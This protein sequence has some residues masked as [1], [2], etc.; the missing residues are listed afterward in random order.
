MKK[1]ISLLLALVM[2]MGLS[3]TAFAAENEATQTGVPTS[4]N[5]AITADYDAPDAQYVHTYKATV[6]WEQTGTIKY[7]AATTVYTWNTDKLEY[8]STSNTENNNWTIDNAKVKITVTNYSDQAIT[9]NLN[10]PTPNSSAG[11]DGI[12]GFY[13]GDKRELK[14]ASAY[15]K[16]GTSEATKDY[17]TFNISTVEG[18]I[19]QQGATIATVT[20]KLSIDNNG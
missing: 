16:D 2:V 19:T 20:V 7:T 9:A 3:V 18:A 12:G 10:A 14:L 11:V 15:V 4:S 13:Y 17:T 8:D 1:I 6:A 5:A